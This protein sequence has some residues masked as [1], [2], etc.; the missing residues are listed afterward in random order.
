[1]NFLTS[2]KVQ[3][4]SLQ[5]EKRKGVTEFIKSQSVQDMWENDIDI[6]LHELVK[7]EKLWRRSLE[8]GSAKKVI[9]KGENDDLIATEDDN[10]SDYKLEVGLYSQ[11]TKKTSK[12][13]KRKRTKT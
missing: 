4:I 3:D 7:I 2:E 9:F 8:I 12:E 11:N 5:I 13:I 10:D 1:M 6:F